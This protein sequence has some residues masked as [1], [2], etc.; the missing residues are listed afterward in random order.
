MKQKNSSAS[1]VSTGKSR[2]KLWVSL[3]VFCLLCLVIA[4][5]GIGFGPKPPPETDLM[6]QLSQIEQGGQTASTE[7]IAFFQEYLSVQLTPG[8]E[9]EETLDFVNQVHAAFLLGSK[10]NLCDPFTL[11]SFQKE[12]EAENQLRAQMDATGEVYFGPQSFDLKGYFGY[13]YSN[14]MASLLT[15]ITEHRDAALVEA[16]H[17]FYERAEEG[18]QEVI[19]VEYDLTENGQ[20]T[21]H[22]LKREDFR[23]V[24]QTEG[25]LM[26]ALDF[27]EDG[28]PVTLSDGR[29]VTRTHMEL[30]LLPFEQNEAYIVQ[31]YLLHERLDQ[32]IR[33]I[34][35]RNPVTLL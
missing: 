24:S 26:D 9:Q 4:A 6:T 35:I 33:E 3:A 28:V 1:A 30:Q 20:T 32:L 31:A 2:K 10:L 27:G 14:L 34:S 22:T 19:W 17:L 16:S 12:M 11:E 25:E 7:E 8:R 18:F 23:A 5:I 21:H 15:W 13:R 29:V